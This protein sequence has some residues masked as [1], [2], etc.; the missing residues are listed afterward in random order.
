LDVSGE[1][2][3]NHYSFYAAFST[4]EEFR[5][6]AEGKLI[7]SLPIAFPVAEGSFLI[8]AGRRWEVM[9]VDMEH[10]VIELKAALGGRAPNF[11]GSGGW[12]EDRVREEMFKVY[13]ST[14]F[15][16]FLDCNARALLNEGRKHFFDLNLPKYSVIGHGSD[17]LI[18]V[19]KGDRILNTLALMLR[20]VGLQVARDGLAFTVSRKTPEEVDHELKSL[21]E[22]G[23]ADAISLAAAIKNKATEKHDRWLDDDI[24]NE[25][26]ASRNLDCQGAW[27]AIC[28]ISGIP[29][30]PPNPV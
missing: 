7:G 18:F 29:F 10:K 9:L 11:V 14:D 3:V 13:T 8:F 12:V 21:A 27:E 17:T 28:R 2:I 25:D 20:S 23:P 16:S 15:P 22:K 4:S 1:R 24:M 26:Y 6:M 19:W 5:L 30:D